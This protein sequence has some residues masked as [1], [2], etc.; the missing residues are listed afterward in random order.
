MS[1]DLNRI[2]PDYAAWIVENFE[3]N[4]SKLEADPAAQKVDNRLRDELKTVN[5][6]GL[7]GLIVNYAR[8]NQAT[9]I[10]AAAKNELTR[11][12]IYDRDIL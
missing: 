7:F 6:E 9:Y 11:R 1:I 2:D 10:E 12:G 5:A 8:P 3:F 4:G